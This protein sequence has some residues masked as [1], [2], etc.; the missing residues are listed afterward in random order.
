MVFRS[1]VRSNFNAQQQQ[2]EPFFCTNP[3]HFSQLTTDSGGP[4]Y[5]Y[6]SNVLYNVGIISFGFACGT[7][8][9]AVNTK[10][11]SYLDWII[12]NT[13]LTSYCAL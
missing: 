2:L 13:P 11:T 9:P 5:L 3:H 10:V 6:D 8:E 7:L 1:Y 12:E 4:L